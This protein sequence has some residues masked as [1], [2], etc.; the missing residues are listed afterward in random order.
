MLGRKYMETK[1]PQQEEAGGD[2]QDKIVG[3]YKKML[4]EL[5][6]T[7]QEERPQIK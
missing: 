1:Y 7:V 5:K 3:F 4:A 2:N 6:S